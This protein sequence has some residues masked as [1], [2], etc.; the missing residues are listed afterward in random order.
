MTPRP[1]RTMTLLACVAVLLAACTSKSPSHPGASSGGPSGSNGTAS[2][3]RLGYNPSLIQATA[4]IGMQDG[5]FN[6]GISTEGHTALQPSTYATAATEVSALQSGSL[7]AGYLDP[8]SAIAAFEATG[9]GIKIIS[10]AT[11]GGSY[12]M[13]TYFAQKVAT[14]LRGAKIAVPEQGTSDDVA[15]RT[16]LADGGVKVGTGGVNIVYEPMSSIV[17]QYGHGLTGAW[18]DEEWASRMQIEHGAT[19]FVDEGQSPLWPTTTYPTAVLVART[20]Y[21]NQYPDTISNLL[22]GQVVAND[23]VKIQTPQNETDAAAAIKTTTGQTINQSESDLAW[24]HLSFTD[25]PNTTAIQTDATKAQKLGLIKTANLAGI[26]DL[27]PLNA[28]L[29]A[30]NEPQVAGG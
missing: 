20:S 30:A 27:Q 24:S 5:I 11:S 23:R 3:L 10:G 21:I 17:A 28:V 15:L 6:Q 2:V 26:F 9:G 16:Y 13:T 4:L 12:L 14:N 1:F 29:Q 18:V 7:D 25:D 19:V 8:N 22:I